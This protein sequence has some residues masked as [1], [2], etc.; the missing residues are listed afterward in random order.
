MQLHRHTNDF[1]NEIL[2]C[3]LLNLAAMKLPTIMEL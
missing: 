1:K 2:T 3:L